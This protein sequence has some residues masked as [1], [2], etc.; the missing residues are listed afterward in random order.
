[1]RVPS[2]PPHSHADVKLM[3]KQAFYTNLNKYEPI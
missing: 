1:M 3:D 2:S